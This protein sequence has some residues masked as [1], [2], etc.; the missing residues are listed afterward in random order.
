ML[1][2]AG[3]QES[4]HHVVEQVWVLFLNIEAGFVDTRKRVMLSDQVVLG[5]FCLGPADGYEVGNSAKK[6]KESLDYSECYR[7]CAK[8]APVPSHGCTILRTKAHTIR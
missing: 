8:S 1:V 4:E 6:E 5:Y 3:S 2:S 7:E